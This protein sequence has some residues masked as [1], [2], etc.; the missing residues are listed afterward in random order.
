MVLR[1]VKETRLRNG[2]HNGDAAKEE[3]AGGKTRVVQ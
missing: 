3:L 2:S 1:R